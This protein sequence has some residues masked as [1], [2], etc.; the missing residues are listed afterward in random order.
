L[1][2]TSSP[3]SQP[4]SETFGRY[5]WAIELLESAGIAGWIVDHFDPAPVQLQIENPVTM[6]LAVA[7]ADLPRSDLVAA[8]SRQ[9]GGFRIQLPWDV[10]MRASTFALS[11][12][13]PEGRTELCRFRLPTLMGAFDQVAQER[14]VEGWAL[15]AADPDLKPRLEVMYRGEVVASGRATMFRPDLRM[16]TGEDGFCGFQIVAP[17]PIEK[18]DAAVRAFLPDGETLLLRG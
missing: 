1:N 13:G 17:M 6:R 7:S 10:R 11:A 3:V 14:L 12:H 15:N 9:V 16:V 4:R 2:V 18:H 5:S 8:F